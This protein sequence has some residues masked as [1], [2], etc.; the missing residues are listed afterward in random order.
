MSDVNVAG[1]SPTVGEIPEDYAAFERH[2]QPSRAAATEEAAEEADTASDGGEA[3]QSD[4][5]G[6]PAT[7]PEGED[8]GDAEKPRKKGGWQR[9]IEKAEREN[10]EL[11]DRLA[12]IEG[13]IAGGTK[14]A[15][16]A[17]A[18]GK[19][20]T[21]RPQTFSGKPKPQ[22]KD[23]DDYDSYTESLTEW[24]LD[25][26][27]AKREHNA[28]QQQ[29]AEQRQTAA[30][31]F[32]KGSEALRTKYADFDEVIDADVTLSAAVGQ[33]LL[34]SE[35]GPEI[36]YYLAKNPAEAERINKLSPLA[37]AREIGKLETKFASS[38]PKP[39][40]VSK[41]AD[42]ITPVNAGGRAIARRFDDPNVEYSAF[43]KQMNSRRRR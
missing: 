39:K 6:T 5:E 20:A 8:E 25:E 18:D 21:D 42:P 16:G 41:A 29:A 30:E 23:F 2:M 14:P 33:C 9:K 12:A 28:K 40:P 24:T 43:E 32:V 4:G 13:T 34:D 35:S 38:T 10:A 27:Q 19:T 11:R 7:E 22:S 31:K 17:T 15:A 3:T 26:G 37:A 1:Q 36:G